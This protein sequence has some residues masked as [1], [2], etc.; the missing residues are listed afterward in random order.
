MPPGAVTFRPVW[1][2]SHTTDQLHHINEAS[3][4]MTLILFTLSKRN[5]TA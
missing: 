3:H 5:V 2:L 4:Q 1:R